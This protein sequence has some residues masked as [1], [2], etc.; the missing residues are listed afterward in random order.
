MP[1]SVR[2]VVLAEETYHLRTEDLG[3]LE[4]CSMACSRSHGDEARS[5]EEGFEPLRVRGRYV[6]VL[7]P[8]VQEDG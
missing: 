7:A 2:F 6:D 8:R 1:G 5:G 4:G 3:L